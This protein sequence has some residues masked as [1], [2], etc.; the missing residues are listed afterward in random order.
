MTIGYACVTFSYFFIILREDWSQLEKEAA[1]RI[2]RDK[3][4][5]NIGNS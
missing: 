1:E 2:E 3:Q 4:Q 5:L